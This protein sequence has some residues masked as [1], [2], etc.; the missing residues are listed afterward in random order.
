MLQITYNEICLKGK[1]RIDFE[2]V[3]RKNIKGS[4]KLNVID[5]EIIQKYSYLNIKFNNEKEEEKAISILGKIFGVNIVYKVVEVERDIDKLLKKLKEL[6]LIKKE[7]NIEV[8]RLDKK[9]RITSQDLRDRIIKEFKEYYVKKSKDKILI[10]IDKNNFQILVVVERGPGGLPSGSTGKLVSLLSD[11]ID[12][13]VASWMML[14]RGAEL[15]LLNIYSYESEKKNIE[16]VANLLNKYSSGRVKLIQYSRDEIFG[17]TCKYFK[18]NSLEDRYKCLIFKNVILLIAQKIAKENDALGIVTGDNLGQV[19][20]QTLENL[21]LTKENIHLPI[22]SPLI[23]LN[24]EEIVE[25]AQK[26]GTF[27][28]SVKNNFQKDYIPKK[29][30]TKGKLEI[31]LK[32][33]EE[34]IKN[35]SRNNVIFT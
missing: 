5:Y 6:K 20:S 3:L 29:P 1:N 31:F 26:I 35:I 13:P 34:V 14:K 32:V 21:Y 25:I 4:L 24:K 23:G 15:I 10:R 12:S 16:E 27:D 17:N 2:R 33:R 28:I 8:K 9:F 22:Y 11:G 7:F 18:R 30:I 19:A